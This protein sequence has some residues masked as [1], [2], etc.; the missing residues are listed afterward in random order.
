MADYT[1]DELIEALKSTEST[2]SKCKK[3]LPKLKEGSSQRTLLTRRIK[4][5]TISIELIESEINAY[6]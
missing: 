5:L 6:M 2:L 4:A 1:K 3:A